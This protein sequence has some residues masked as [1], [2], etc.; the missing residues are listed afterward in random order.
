ME[1]ECTSAASLPQDLGCHAAIVLDDRGF[2][3][4]GEHRI[5]LFDEV[6]QHLFVNQK[7]F[8]T[9]TDDEDISSHSLEIHADP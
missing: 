5:Q 4:I 6:H 1:P 3:G 8:R 9:I 2:E 7:P